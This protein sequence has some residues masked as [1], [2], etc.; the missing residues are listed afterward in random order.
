LIDVFK[1]LGIDIATINKEPSYKWINITG[2]VKSGKTEFCVNLSKELRTVYFDFE[3]GSKAYVGS[4]IDVDNLP[5]LRS[6]MVR[7]L[8][9][10]EAINP[11]VI[12]LDP[13][14]KLANMISKWY[15]QDKGIEDLSEMP[16]GSGW[17]GTRDIL[18]NFIN[19]CFKIAPL[20]ITVTH[21]KLAS[22]DVTT[23]NVT[24]LDMDLP[25]KTKRMVHDTADA[26]CIFKPE[27]DD[28]GKHYL[29]VSFDASSTSS[30]G[31]G[32]SRV[33]DFYNIKTA[34]DLMKQ[35]LKKF[36]VAK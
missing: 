21:L 30:F 32:G 6:K 27:K 11:D 23:K 28:D 8:E 25:G 29:G 33:K 36:D 35:V 34:D 18:F 19:T 4:F 5:D 13:I 20:L 7:V 31:F 1:D 10:I 9:N 15:C 26:H 22:S 14:D 16:Y 24:Y 2:S 3:K 17:S 12:V